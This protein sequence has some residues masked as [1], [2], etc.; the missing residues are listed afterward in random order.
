MA[1]YDHK[2]IE[3]RWQERWARARIAEVDLKA[4]AKPFYMLMMYP[5]PSGDRLHVGH[6]RNYIMGD[7][8]YRYRRMRGDHILNPMGWD[9]FGLPAENA[10]IARSV[11]PRDSTLENIRRKTAISNESTVRTMIGQLLEFQIVAEKTQAVGPVF[12][13]QA[14]AV[15]PFVQRGGGEPCRNAHGKRG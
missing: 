5:Y 8:L 15:G 13:E 3:P 9:S 14:D 10:A 1:D 6:G 4:A 11:H 7:A 12:A 2:S